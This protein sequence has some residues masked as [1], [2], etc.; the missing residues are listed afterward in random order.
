M[1]KKKSMEAMT[2]WC[3]P[4]HSPALVA[5]V[6]KWEYNVCPACPYEALLTHAFEVSVIKKIEKYWQRICEKWCCKTRR[7][8]PTGVHMRWVVGAVWGLARHTVNNVKHIACNASGQLWE[9]VRL[10]GVDKD[11]E[12]CVEKWEGL[13]WALGRQY[14]KRRLHSKV[15]I[16]WKVKWSSLKI[17]TWPH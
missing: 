4:T 1:C 5:L 7:R 12:N 9:T 6:S 15:L 16:G 14:D 17:K 2:C 3:V 13:Q 10:I 8:T 11:M